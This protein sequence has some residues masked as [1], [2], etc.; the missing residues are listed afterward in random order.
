MAL[1]CA[2]QNEINGEAAKRLVAQ[3]VICVS[4]GA[5]M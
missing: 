5:N 4:E 2:T 1:P 3:G